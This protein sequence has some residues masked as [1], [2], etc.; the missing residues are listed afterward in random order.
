MSDYKKVLELAKGY[1]HG[2]AVTHLPESQWT[3]GERFAVSLLAAEEMLREAESV[4]E[5]C[6]GLDSFPDAL[7]FLAKRK[8][9]I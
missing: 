1:A 7:A 4:I 8:E 6:I 2:V 5:R 3:D 9:M